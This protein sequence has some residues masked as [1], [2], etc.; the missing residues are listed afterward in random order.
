MKELLLKIKNDIKEYRQLDYKIKKPAIIWTLIIGLCL[1]ISLIC[2]VS[3]IMV[4]YYGNKTSFLIIL[5]ITAFVIYLLQAFVLTMY[6]KFLV[7]NLDYEKRVPFFP[8]YLYHLL[9][10]AMIITIIV[11]TVMAYFI[12][13]FVF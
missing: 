1:L 8:Y 4:N 10:I 9:D 12:I 3:P 2:I 11:L 13:R 6:Y 5:I 7:V